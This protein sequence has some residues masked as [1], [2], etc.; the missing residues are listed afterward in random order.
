MPVEQ[1]VYYNKD[2][3]E[4]PCIRVDTYRNDDNFIQHDLRIFGY[5]CNFYGERELDRKL[6]FNLERLDGTDLIKMGNRLIQI[7]NTDNDKL[8]KLI[9]NIVTPGKDVMINTIKADIEINDEVSPLGADLLIEGKEF[10]L[11]LD[12][13]GKEW[14]IYNRAEECVKEYSLSDVIAAIRFFVKAE[15]QYAA[16]QQAIN[17]IPD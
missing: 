11:Y 9:E 12:I 10:H 13:E 8:D 1:P 15:I 17:Q 5:P 14:Q 7:G 16:Y 3:V 6:W 2:E 4:D